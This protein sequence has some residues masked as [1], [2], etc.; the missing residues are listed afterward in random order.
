MVQLILPLHRQKEKMLYN[1]KT[2]VNVIK[3]FFFVTDFGSNKL[4]VHFKSFYL[5]LCLENNLKADL[6]G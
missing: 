5:W 6:L 1:I 3:R 2:G 4:G